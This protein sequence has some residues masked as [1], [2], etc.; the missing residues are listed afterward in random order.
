VIVEVKP[1]P[2]CDGSIQ[3]LANLCHKCKSFY[4][5]ENIIISGLI[6]PQER[7]KVHYVMQTKCKSYLKNNQNVAIIS[8]SSPHKLR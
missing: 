1:S 7:S 2:P 3:K 6:V 8:G 5:H 4:L